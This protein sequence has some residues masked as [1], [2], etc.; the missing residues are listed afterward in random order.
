MN[1]YRISPF[2][3]F[4][5]LCLYNCINYT[6]DYFK[7]LYCEDFC[8]IFFMFL[9]FAEPPIKLQPFCFIFHIPVKNHSSLYSIL[10]LHMCLALPRLPSW[11]V[12][13]FLLTRLY[14]HIPTFK[15]LKLGSAG[16]RGR[17]VP[18]ILNLGYCIHYNF[19]VIYIFFI[20]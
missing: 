14:R 1:L 19:L 18:I 2:K 10:F 8:I 13:H 15:T 9:V 7:N 16:K 6:E 20:P 3:I 5:K 12:E 11:T 4:L 17:M